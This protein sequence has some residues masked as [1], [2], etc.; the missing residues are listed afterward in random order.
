[1]IKRQRGV[2]KWSVKLIRQ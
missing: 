2:M 1:M